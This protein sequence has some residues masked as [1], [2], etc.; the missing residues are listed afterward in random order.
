MK[1]KQLSLGQLEVVSFETQNAPPRPADANADAGTCLDT[2]CGNIQ[3]C[4]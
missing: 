2:N 3:C 4:A 1:F